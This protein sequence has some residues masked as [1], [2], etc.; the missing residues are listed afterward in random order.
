MKQGKQNISENRCGWGKVYGIVY[1]YWVGH[2][3]P[4]KNGNCSSIR[5]RKLLG[6]RLKMA[7]RNK[8][9]MD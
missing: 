8:M 6:Y 4:L 5:N 7:P 2:G 3:L 1:V 9:K